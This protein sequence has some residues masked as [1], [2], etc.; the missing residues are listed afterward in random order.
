ML[1][2]G[3]IEG[4]TAENFQEVCR[5]KVNGTL[6]L[7][8]VTRELCNNTL[9]WFVAFS[10]ISSGSGNAGQSNYGYANSVME[11]ICEKRK[12]DGLPGM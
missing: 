11:R 5:P 2:D 8:L 7:D 10:S 6:N 3:L 9:D 4:Q 1:K 12:Q